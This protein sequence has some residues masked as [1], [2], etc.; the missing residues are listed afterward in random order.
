MYFIIWDFREGSQVFSHQPLWIKR[1]HI[2]EPIPSKLTV[3]SFYRSLAPGAATPPYRTWDEL[4]LHKEGNVWYKCWYELWC[5]LCQIPQLMLEVL[6]HISPSCLWSDRE[7]ESSL[8]GCIIHYWAW[9][10]ASSAFRG[11][12]LPVGKKNVSVPYELCVYH[13][14][15]VQLNIITGNSDL[16]TL[17]TELEC[18][19]CIIYL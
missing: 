17:L 18:G 14:S 16:S 6:S 9:L 19:E 13:P 11:T 2:S 3:A 12:Q 8:H 4:S 15:W 10:K 1:P 5:S 7:R